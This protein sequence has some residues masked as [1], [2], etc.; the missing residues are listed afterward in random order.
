MCPRR[1]EHEP[2]LESPLIDLDN[3]ATLHL[4]ASIAEAQVSV[5][6]EVA[7]DVIMVEQ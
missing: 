3:V 5:A 7:K 1:Y 6:R 2:P 4:G